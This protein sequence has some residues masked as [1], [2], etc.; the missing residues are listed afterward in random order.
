MSHRRA[1]SKPQYKIIFTGPVGAGKTTAVAALSDTPVVR[2]DALA[3]DMTSR[4]KAETTVAMDYGVLSLEGGEKIHLYGT[5][6]QER[7]NFM[8]DILT[9]GGIGL[10][11]L[12]DN[13][14]ADPFRD[15]RFFLEAFREFIGRTQAVIGVTHYDDKAT[16]SLNEYQ[17][18]L[19]RLGFGPM[20][21]YEVDARNRRDVGMLVRS[22]LHC[23]DPGLETNVA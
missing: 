7:F 21:V 23:L 6:G 5:P 22:L 14:R 8:W 3:T 19:K 13:S 1:H 18:E 15:V 2:T 9:E 20:P 12:V 16:P 11:L 10:V 4:R 17:S